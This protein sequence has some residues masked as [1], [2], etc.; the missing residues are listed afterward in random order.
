MV[1]RYCPTIK[2]VSDIPK[3]DQSTCRMLQIADTIGVFQIESRAQMSSCRGSSATTRPR[4]L[5]GCSTV[6]PWGFTAPHS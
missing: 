4:L 1:Q 5:L 2:T 6:S 3:D